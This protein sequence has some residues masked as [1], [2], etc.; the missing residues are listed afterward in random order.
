MPTIPRVIKRAYRKILPVSI[1]NSPMIDLLKGKLLA[2]DAIYDSEYYETIA[3]GPAARSAG[4]ISDSILSE[5][6]P[7]SVVDVGCGTGAMLHA[8]RERG[9]KVFGLEYS[10]AALVYCRKR[11]L[12]VR[13]FDLENDMLKNDRKFDLALSVEVAEHLPESVADRYVDL[14]ASLSKVIVFTAAPPGQGGSDHVN[15][16]PPSYWIAKFHQR[17]YEHGHDL[18][19][20][21]GDHWKASGNVESWYYQNLMIFRQ[22]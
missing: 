13:K 7:R 8:L 2:H 1:R 4:T 19:R 16:Q 6:N 12:D 3:E 22:I 20:R 18:S 9:C 10:E 11:Q 21:W 14:L 17:G 15:E 5:F